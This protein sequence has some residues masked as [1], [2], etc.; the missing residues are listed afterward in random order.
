MSIQ[1]YIP[2]L[3]KVSQEVIAVLAATLI[4]A[5]LISKVPAWKNLVR[6]NSIPSPFD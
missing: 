1:K 3:P 4:A 6:E 5:W 2:D